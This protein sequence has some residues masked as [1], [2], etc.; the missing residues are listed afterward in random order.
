MR[1]SNSCS[2]GGTKSTWASIKRKCTVYDVFEPDV[3][4]KKIAE[5]DS[6]HDCAEFLGI[7]GSGVKNIINRKTRHK[8]KKL[9][10]VIAIR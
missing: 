4:K 2:A 6:M 10:K 1:Y 9:N 8:S 7:K 5:F 3:S